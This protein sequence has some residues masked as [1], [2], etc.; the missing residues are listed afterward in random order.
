MAALDFPASPSVG[1]VYSA[2][3]VTW[4]WNGTV[5]EPQQ[6]K[7]SRASF[8]RTTNFNYTLGGAFAQVP[9]TAEAYDPDGI[10]AIT[11]GDVLLEPGTYYAV[12]SIGMYVFSP[13]ASVGGNVDAQ[14][15]NQSDS[16]V[17]AKPYGAYYEFDSAEIAGRTIPVIV[18]GTFTIAST[19]LIRF[20]IAC[21]NTA[22]AYPNNNNTA[23]ITFI[24]LFP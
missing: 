17:I 22:D 5:W 19:K 21:T 8:T 24:R 13:S 2:N 20:R 15:Y 18:A 12:A 23:E 16:I 7:N 11:S 10:G 6:I 4:K 1:Q 14:I 9:F 3:G